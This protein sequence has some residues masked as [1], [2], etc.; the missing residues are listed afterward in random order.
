MRK[1][2]LSPGAKKAYEAIQSCL[3]PAELS[4][5]A[6]KAYVVIQRFVD[7]IPPSPHRTLLKDFK[8]SMVI[9]TDNSIIKFGE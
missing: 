7:A 2:K 6:Q 9:M 3:V 5:E 4:L 1:N 8:G